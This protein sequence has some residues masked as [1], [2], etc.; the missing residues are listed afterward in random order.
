V[1][2]N[3]ED[4][5]E[6]NLRALLDN[7]SRQYVDPDRLAIRVYTNVKQRNDFAS[8]ILGD[9]VAPTMPEYFV[10]AIFRD[11]GNEVIRYRPPNGAV[12][13]VLVRGRDIFPNL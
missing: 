3:S 6:A 10:A 9:Y 11:S 8:L 13:T 1:F 7:F 12:I 4:G 2:I 5:G